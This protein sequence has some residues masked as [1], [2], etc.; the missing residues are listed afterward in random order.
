MP[1]S[2][3]LSQFLRRDVCLAKDRS[4]RSGGKITVAVHWHDDQWSAL[5]SPK[6]VVAA[7]D[8][9]LLETGST[10][11]AEKGPSADTRKAGQGAATSISTM[12][13]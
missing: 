11:S 1:S 3:K 10:Q 2:Q 9:C 8:V 4:Q 6:V 12:S 5:D 7:A 13:T